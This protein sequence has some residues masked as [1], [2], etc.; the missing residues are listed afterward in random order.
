MTWSN[1]K[2]ATRKSK[3]WSSGKETDEYNVTIRQVL[4]GILEVINGVIRAGKM[5]YAST[6]PGFWLGRDTDGQIKLNLGTAAHYLKWNGSALEISGNV[7]AGAGAIVLDEDGLDVIAADSY[8]DKNAVRWS[9]L[10]GEPFTHRIYALLTVGRSDMVQSV[11]AAGSKDSFW[12]ARATAAAG[13]KAVTTLQATDS[14]ADSTLLTLRRS[15]ANGSQV[16]LTGYGG[17]KVQLYGSLCVSDTDD[18][19]LTTEGSAAVRNGFTAGSATNYT[20]FDH[21]GHQ[22]MTGSARPWRDELGQ[23]LGM[24]RKGTRITEDLDEGT[25]MFSDACAIADDYAVTNI[26]LNH[27][28][29]PAGAISP[30]LHW[31]QSS[32]AVPNWLLQYRWQTQGTAKATAWTSAK[33]AG[34][35]FTYTSGALN[36]I[37]KWAAISPPS[38]AGLSDIVQFRITRDTANASTLFS[39]AD[40]LTGPAAAVMFDAHFQINSLGSND[41]YTK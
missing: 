12:T 13:Q 18:D 20:R 32:A 11:E 27:D 25:V 9:P 4:E 28:K 7:T 8:A 6:T 30:H 29:D 3:G 26:E 5:S 34:H 24:K 33:Y 17:A 22:T 15:T 31:V 39:G 35:A 2:N 19:E 23:L 14:A 10:H 36:Q 21:T 16:Q 1:W 37:T 41:E 38:G 40:P